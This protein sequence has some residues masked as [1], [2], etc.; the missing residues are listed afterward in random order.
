MVV[1]ITEKS[2]SGL[3]GQGEFG[4]KL[5]ILNGV[6]GEGLWEKTQWSKEEKKL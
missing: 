1:S 3:A 6:F 5:T 2:K 4:G